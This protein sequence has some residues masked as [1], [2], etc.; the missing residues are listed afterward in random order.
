MFKIKAYISMCGDEYVA[1]S[2]IRSFLGNYA[3]EKGQP[4]SLKKTSVRGRHVRAE[5]TR[6]DFHHEGASLARND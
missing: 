5:L 3:G 1:G 6:L 4:A 2:E